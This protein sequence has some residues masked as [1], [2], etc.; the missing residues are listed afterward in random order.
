MASESKADCV[1]EAVSMAV[2]AMKIVSSDE[3]AKVAGG[4]ASST[5]VTSD[6]FT[7][8]VSPDPALPCLTDRDF[9]DNLKKWYVNSDDGGMMCAPS[10]RN[11]QKFVS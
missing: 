3:T 1:E 4:D 9:K 6:V 7:F 5:A 8:S 10:A 2:P 11:L